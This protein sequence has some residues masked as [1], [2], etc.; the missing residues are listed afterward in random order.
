MIQLMRYR[1]ENDG[2]ILY[3][4]PF[5]PDSL[6]DDF[7]IK[8]G[9]WYVDE[10]G[11]LIGENPDNTAAMVMTRENFV[12]DVLVEFDAST[13]MPATR[14]INVTW[15]GS[16][17]EE[18]NCRG[19]AYVAG[20]QGWWQGLVG[21]EKSPDYK[22][23]AGTK[24]FPFEAGRVYHVAVGSVGRTQFIAIDGVLALEIHDPEPLG[25]EHGRVG[26]EAFCT[27]V[28]YRNLVIR[29]M[30]AVDTWVKY[31]PEF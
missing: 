11:W 27:R 31:E 18:K 16:W 4:R 5:T 9:K 30:H 12:G 13:V 6:R 17:D 14:D 3:N 22:L 24:L 25:E 21:F 8:D 19:A 26:F 2:E 23:V 10:S 1:V 29:R 15:H 7:E 20:I 28:R